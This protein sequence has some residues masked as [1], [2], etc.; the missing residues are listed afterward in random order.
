MAEV[1]EDIPVSEIN[2]NDHVLD[3]ALLIRGGLEHGFHE[4]ANGDVV[5]ARLAFD[6]QHLLGINA[7]FVDEGFDPVF[8]GVVFVHAFNVA[9]GYMSARIIFIFFQI[10]FRRLSK[11][12]QQSDAANRRPRCS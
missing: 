8:E 3:S 9:Y 12:A 4:A 6:D 10:L 5:R 7:F 11:A 2:P 1:V